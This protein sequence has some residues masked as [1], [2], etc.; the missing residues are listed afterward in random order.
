MKRKDVVQLIEETILYGASTDED[1]EITA[2]K[3]LG[4][5]EELRITSVWDREDL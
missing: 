2:D 5:L 1:T 3:I 4:E